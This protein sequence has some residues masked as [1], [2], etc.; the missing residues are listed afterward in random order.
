MAG[1]SEDRQ[2]IDRGV[3]FLMHRQMATG[4]FN[5]S[6][7]ITYTAYKNVFPIWELLRYRNIY[8]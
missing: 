1:E 5:R 8:E 7:G 6:C 2:A 4:E 3:N